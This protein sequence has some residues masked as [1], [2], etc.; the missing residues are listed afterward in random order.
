MDEAIFAIFKN[1]DLDFWTL[2]IGIS[3]IGFQIRTRRPRIRLYGNF[4]KI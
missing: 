2:D 4:G 1:F 3:K